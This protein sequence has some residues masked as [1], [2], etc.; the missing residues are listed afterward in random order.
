MSRVLNVVLAHSPPPEIARL[1]AWWTNITPQERLLLVHGGPESCFTEIEFGNKVHVSSERLRTVDHP[2]D[3]QGYT[4]VFAAASEWMRGRDFS[5][6]YFAEFDH[7]PLVADLDQRLLRLLDEERADVL[8]YGVRRVDDTGWHHYLYHSSNPA[9]HRHW[10][11]VSVRSNRRVVLCM[12]GTGSFWKREVFDAVAASREPFPI[13]LELY[14]PTLAHHLGFRVRD[15]G[16]QNRFVRNLGDMGADVAEARIAGAWT[17][18]P[19][20]HLWDRPVDPALLAAVGH[21]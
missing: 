8:G 12:L 15:M 18:H 2:R 9:F 17:V 19:V 6:V 1:V 10:E 13:Y 7:L 16:V 5:H 11:G 4:E 3:R 20:K 14:L 21:R